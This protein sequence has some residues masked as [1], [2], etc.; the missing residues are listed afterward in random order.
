MFST[1]LTSIVFRSYYIYRIGDNLTIAMANVS[2]TFGSYLEDFL[3]KSAIF[4][5]KTRD[6]QWRRLSLLAIFFGWFFSWNTSQARR[7]FST[8][9]LSRNFFQQWWFSGKIND[10]S[11]TLFVYICAQ[12]PIVTL[13]SKKS[14]K[15]FEFLPKSKKRIANIF[16]VLQCSSM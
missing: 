6:L 11:A 8:T 9:L 14:P 10:K 1:L 13:S 7:N 4:C 2:W 16:F 15:I 3:A 5:H 12:L